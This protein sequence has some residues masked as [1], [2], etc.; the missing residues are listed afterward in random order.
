[1]NHLAHLLLSE[2]E[3]GVMVGNLMGDFLRGP[4][5]EQLPPGVQR[6]VRLHRR[7]D[8]FTDDHP[9]FRRSRRRFPAGYRRYAGI[10]LDVFFD[11]L[12]ARH[13]DRY[14]PL[15]LPE[16]S[17]RVYALL[18][19][20]RELM[21][22]TMQ[23]YVYYMREYDLLTAYRRPDSVQRVL[24]RIARRLRRDNPLP[25]AGP[26]LERLRP[27]LEPD[28][29]AFFPELRAYIAQQTGV[30]PGDLGHLPERPHR[31]AWPR[32]DL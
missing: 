3:P 2:P 20:E 7:I 24:D 13:W 11:H 4:V 18:E 15:P 29:A 25:S 10:M 9:V 12:L 1:M 6:G 21:P 5:D 31:G 22:R 14:A 23:R 8:A 30:R 27:A 17:R 16:F 32:T 19:S 28:F 26:E